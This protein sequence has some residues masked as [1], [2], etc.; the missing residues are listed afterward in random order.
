MARETK[1]DRIAR[2]IHEQVGEHLHELKALEANPNTKETD[3]ERWVQSFFRACLG[4]T[5]STGYQVRA[6][7]AKGKMRPDLIVLRNE[8]PVFVIEVKKLGFDL[9]KSDFRSGKLQL[10]EYLNNI[11]NVK[12]G[13]LSNGH[14]WRLYDFSQ[15]QY[16]GIEI[17]SIDFRTD[18]DSIDT[19]KRAVEELC[20]ELIELHESSFN[21][22][23]WTDLSKEAMA[24]SPE[25]LARAVLS[26]DSVRLISRIIRGEHEYKAN[27]EVLT[28]KIYDL[29]ANGLDDSIPGWNEAK[30]SEFQKYIK[31]QKRASR[32]QKRSRSRQ[33]VSGESQGIE[34]APET[35]AVGDSS[36]EGSQE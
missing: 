11:G 24:F 7:E 1:Q 26:N 14:E 32:K 22:D 29:L 12:W 36:S 30:Q 2:T 34:E 5:S 13:L 27:Q 19:S 25:S 9:G 35:A 3:V 21:G 6:Q 10:G 20:Y 17:L 15:P 33:Q 31:S 16:G 23:S 18:S 28:D 8:K 4:Y